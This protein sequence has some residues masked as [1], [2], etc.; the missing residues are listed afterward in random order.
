MYAIKTIFDESK[1]R[2]NFLGNDYD[3]FYKTE[4]KEDEFSYYF[5]DLFPNPEINDTENVVA[6][7]SNGE[8]MIPLYRHFTYYIVMA[9][10]GQTFKKLCWNNPPK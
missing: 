6:I 8:I 3:L 4:S 5:K 1:E 7:I 2:V 10:T 9:D